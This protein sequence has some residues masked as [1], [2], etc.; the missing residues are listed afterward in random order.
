MQ[1]KF[2]NPTSH[3]QRASHISCDLSYSPEII[4]VSHNHTSNTPYVHFGYPSFEKLINV[5]LRCNCISSRNNYLQYFV[6]GKASI[7]TANNTCTLFPCRL[8]GPMQ[9]PAKAVRGSQLSALGA[10]QSP[11]GH[12]NVRSVQGGRVT[13]T[14]SV[15]SHHHPAKGEEEQTSRDVPTTQSCPEP[16]TKALEVEANPA[17]WTHSALVLLPKAKNWTDTGAW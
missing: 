3:I 17:L 9:Q 1:N 11:R 2:H 10:G 4:L 14:A 7:G 12:M 13:S 15:H 5:I 6:P 16:A 8:M